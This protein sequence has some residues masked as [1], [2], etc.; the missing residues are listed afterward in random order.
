MKAQA[1]R[2]FFQDCIFVTWQG[3]SVSR[4]SVQVQCPSG[5]PVHL[6]FA[7]ASLGLI[8]F[9]LFKPLVRFLPKGCMDLF[10]EVD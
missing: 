8:R 1:F 9:H 3:H 4:M 6:A 5:Q 7:F 10:V 2:A